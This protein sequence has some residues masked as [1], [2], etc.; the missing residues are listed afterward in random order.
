MSNKIWLFVKYSACHI[1][2]LQSQWMNEVHLYY[3]LQRNGL[4]K[5]MTVVSRGPIS[6]QRFA[7]SSRAEK[8]LIKMNMAFHIG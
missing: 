3:L 2:L 4:R 5:V 7:Y 1:L 6:K 8:T